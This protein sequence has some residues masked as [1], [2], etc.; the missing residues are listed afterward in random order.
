LSPKVE[1]AKVGSS[2]KLLAGRRRTL[3]RKVFEGAATEPT[4]CL[5]VDCDTTVPAIGLA[6]SLT[7]A[8][9]F[10]E[11]RFF[12]F[13]LVEGTAGEALVVART[14][15]VKTTSVRTT[16][17]MDETRIFMGYRMRPIDNR[18]NCGNL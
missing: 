16:G 1:S 14:T 15:P 13:F 9:D 5:L 7:V 18:T 17:K 10:V 4:N 3:G 8:A 11:D 2:H 12:R 6:A